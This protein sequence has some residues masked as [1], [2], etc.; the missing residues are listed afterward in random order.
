M[1]AHK[2]SLFNNSLADQMLRSLTLQCIT[3]CRELLK[4]VQSCFLKALV[5]K[6]V[7]SEGEGIIQ[8]KVLMFNQKRNSIPAVS[9]LLNAH[10]LGQ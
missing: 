6:N 7:A 8:V 3:S 4:G 9:S 1:G 5:F 10:I 2:E